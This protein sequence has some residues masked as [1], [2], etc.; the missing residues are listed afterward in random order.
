MYGLGCSMHSMDDLANVG[1]RTPQMKQRNKPK[2]VES[3]LAKPNKED[4]QIKEEVKV[5]EEEKKDK[6]C[7]TWLHSTAMCRLLW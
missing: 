4:K 7:C 3:P 1:V 5:T 6:T 2:H